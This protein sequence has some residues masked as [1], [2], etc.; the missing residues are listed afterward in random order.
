[1]KSYYLKP[2]LPRKTICTH[3]E[4]TFEFTSGQTPLFC[5]EVECQIMREIHI[6]ETKKYKQR[7]E[8]KDKASPKKPYKLRGVKTYADYLEKDKKKD[9]SKYKPENIKGEKV[10]SRTPH[11]GSSSANF[12][13]TMQII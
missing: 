8:L 9:W 4:K 13:R 6:Q 2:R 5:K 12:R 11:S 1:M 3:C 7:P 10:E